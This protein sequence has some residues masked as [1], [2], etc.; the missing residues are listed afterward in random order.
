MIRSYQSTMGFFHETLK[1][2]LSMRSSTLAQGTEFYIVNLLASLTKLDQEAKVGRDVPL[3]FL[4]AQAC[5]ASSRFEKIKNFRVLGD[6]SLFVSGLF[7]DCLKEQVVD[8]DYYMSMGSNAYSVLSNISDNQQF[9]EIFVELARKFHF[10]V[11]VL[12]EIG[13]DFHTTSDD[14][15]IRLYDRWLLTRSPR[16]YEMLKKK[17]LD[18]ELMERPSR[19]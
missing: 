18:P 16:L 13:E 2:K 15:L 9:S 10:V 4:Y 11:D 12:S 1:N 5:D 19:M 14:D 6:H 3:A 17:G 7:G 8:L